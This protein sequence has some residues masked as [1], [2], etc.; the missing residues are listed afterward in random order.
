MF[1]SS[2]LL[3]SHPKRG[4]N[5]GQTLRH[6]LLWPR[7]TLQPLMC[8]QYS[9]IQVPTHVMRNSVACWVQ[10]SISCKTH[11]SQF[12]QTLLIVLPKNAIGAAS[13]SKLHPSCLRIALWICCCG[14]KLSAN[15]LALSVTSIQANCGHSVFKLQYWL[16][17]YLHLSS[18]RC[19]C[20]LAKVTNITSFDSSY[21]NLRD[22]HTP[23]TVRNLL[24]CD[25]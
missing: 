1:H 23:T 6:M 2:V 17:F 12:L 16:Q 19:P 22:F 8:C 4:S 18:V 9:I 15:M 10:R 20:A 21:M 14:V 3:S 25:S 13:H 11:Q 7:K 5:P 24:L